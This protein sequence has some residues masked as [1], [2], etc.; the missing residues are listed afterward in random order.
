MQHGAHVS[1]S[2]YTLSPECIATNILMFQI[3]FWSDFKYLY[4]IALFP[5]KTDE[6]TN[7]LISRFLL[8]YWTLSRRWTGK[9]LFF[10][11]LPQHLLIVIS[12]TAPFHERLSREEA[13][14]LFFFLFCISIVL[15]EESPQT[16]APLTLASVPL[17]LWASIGTSCP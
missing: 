2:E 13:A 4:F 14:L 11:T 6:R 1:L 15:I 12:D 5:M 16:V 17:S 8:A 10:L 7:T 3:G 9:M